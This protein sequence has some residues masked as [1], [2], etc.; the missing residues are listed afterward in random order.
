MKI[1]RNPRIILLFGVLGVTSS[2]FI[3]KL[4][5]QPAYILAFSRVFLTGIIAYFLL[6]KN[7]KLKLNKLELMK[8]AIA[9][10]ALATH[11]GWWFDSL[12]Y[13]PIATSLSLTNTA[14]IWLAILSHIT[15]KT[16]LFKRQVVSFILILIASMSL[17]LSSLNSSNI[18]TEGLI[19]AIGSAIGFAIYLI[20][21]KD[22][23]PK[24]GLWKYFGLV[25][26]IASFFLFFMTIVNQQNIYLIDPNLWFYGFLL[27]IFPGLLGHAIY[28]WAM[29][30]LN[31]IDVG[32]STLGEPILGSI[33]AFIILNEVLNQI[34]LSSFLILLIAIVFSLDFPSFKYSN[35]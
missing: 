14:P 8:V 19:L 28:N 15:Y 12:N 24:L 34:E 30:K 22:M 2:S 25:N 7:F 9:G 23:V 5:N 1:H 17:F 11:F 6:N 21:A 16:G 10:L 3:I 4:S 27:A 35:P 18:S 32:V 33:F 31:T 26:L 29:P 13:L 20:L